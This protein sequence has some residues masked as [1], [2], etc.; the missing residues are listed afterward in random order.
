M[1]YV[2]A[3]VATR[4]YVK[5]LPLN[6]KNCM[7]PDV[8]VLKD[9]FELTNVNPDGIDSVTVQ[10]TGLV[11]RV[12][13]GVMVTTIVAPGETVVA[14]KDLVTLPALGAA[15]ACAAKIASTASTAKESDEMCFIV[16]ILFTSFNFYKKR[17]EPSGS[18][19]F[20]LVSFHL[21]LFQQVGL[22]YSCS[23]ATI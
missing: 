12:V 22:K 2:P 23:T 17:M 1:V 14:D 5:G 19:L 10:P 13:L 6:W 11:G 4:V 7:P 16:F 21:S 15:I 20:F 8:V 9:A 18:I 3:V